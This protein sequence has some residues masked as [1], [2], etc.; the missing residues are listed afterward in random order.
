MLDIGCC[1][2]LGGGGGFA[3]GKTEVSKRY[4]QSRA[5]SHSEAVEVSGV[6]VMPVNLGSNW[7]KSTHFSV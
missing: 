1:A 4:K 7:T 6:T 5:S 2:K 3:A